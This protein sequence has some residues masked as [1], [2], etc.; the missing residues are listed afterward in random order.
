MGV[1][2]QAAVL[3]SLILYINAFAPAVLL[4]FLFI[5]SIKSSSLRTICVILKSPFQIVGVS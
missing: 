2:G 4:E 3:V 5:V 1:T